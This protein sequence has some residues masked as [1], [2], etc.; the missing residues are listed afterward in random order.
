MTGNSK[1]RLIGYRII[2]VH[3]YSGKTCKLESLVAWAE[4][5]TV[6]AML[7][8]LTLTYT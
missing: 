7:S 2:M 4:L 3:Y 8:K 6:Y 5:A 1:T